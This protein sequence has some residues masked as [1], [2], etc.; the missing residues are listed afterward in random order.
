LLLDDGGGDCNIMALRI[1]ICGA[2]SILQTSLSNKLE[3]I[4]NQNVIKENKEES[5][6]PDKNS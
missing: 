2:V 1:S 5:Q 6:T 4:M 3:K